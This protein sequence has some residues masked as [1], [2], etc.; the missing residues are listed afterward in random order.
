MWRGRASA[1]AAEENKAAQNFF[2]QAIALDPGFAPG[3]SGYAL[4]YFWDFWPYSRRP[5]TEIQTTALQEARLAVTLDDK[6]AM[7]HAVPGGPAEAGGPLHS[8]GQTLKL[9]RERSPRS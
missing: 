7:A 8:S 6:D 4:A 9:R 2:R 5:Y 3:H 1:A